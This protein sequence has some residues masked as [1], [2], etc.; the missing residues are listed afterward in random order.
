M[1]RA[2]PSLLCFPSVC[3]SNGDVR[4]VGPN[5][6]SGVGIV[7]VYLNQVWGS[8]QPSDYTRVGQAAC[9]QLGYDDV[10]Y[11]GPYDTQQ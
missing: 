10:I 3:Q 1:L 9:R 7:E 11:S 4:L 5:N 2:L 6:S 8:V